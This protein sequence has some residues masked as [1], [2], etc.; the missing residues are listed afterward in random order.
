MSKMEELYIINKSRV[1]MLN[2]MITEHD[3]CVELFISETGL[4]NLYHKYF[5]IAP[6]HY[7]LKIHMKK[8]KTLL[9]TTDRSIST[10]AGE[11]NYMNSNKFAAAF[12]REFQLTPFQYRKSLK[13]GCDK[14]QKIPSAT[15]N[16][17]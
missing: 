6:K 2:S 14:T 5:G 17:M 15:T 10:I 3:L 13:N 12:K 4:R 16:A 9:R 8:A 1:L 7:M 11:L